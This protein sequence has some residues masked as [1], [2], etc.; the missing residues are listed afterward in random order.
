[1]LSQKNKSIVNIH[2][3]LQKTTIDAI[4]HRGVFIE[5]CII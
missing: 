5:I 1:M 3:L 4:K 2:K